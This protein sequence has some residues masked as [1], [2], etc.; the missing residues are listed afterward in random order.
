[1]FMVLIP[2]FNLAIYLQAHKF[3][4]KKKSRTILYSSF[5]DIPEVF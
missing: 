3:P 2:G 1:M 4:G 5:L